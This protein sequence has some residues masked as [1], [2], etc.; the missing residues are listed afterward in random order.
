MTVI[1]VPATSANIGPGFDCLGLALSIYNTFTVEPADHDIL[2]NVEPRFNNRDNLFLQAYRKGCDALHVQDHIH[3]TF[4]CD[5]PVSRGLGSSAA[6]I[7][8]GIAAASA[9]HHNELSLFQIFELAAQMEGHPDNAAPAVYGGLNAC[10]KENGRYIHA[11]LPLSDR[12]HYTVLIPDH[13]IETDAA[14]R[15]LP[16]EYPRADAASNT[17]HGILLVHALETGDVHLL[18]EAA[19]DIIHEPYRARLIPHFDEAK[20]AVSAR[21]NGAFVISGSGSTCL[22]ISDAD[23]H[24]AAA[25]EIRSFHDPDWQIIPSS[26][27]EGVQIL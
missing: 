20:A 6:L 11:A 22:L 25:S 21:N 17:A 7:V 19:H 2:T 8:G 16:A 3:V 23:L 9:L 14:R 26:I 5:I 1:K 12:F 15:I 24:P 13:E 4:Q 27:G 18:H 10:L